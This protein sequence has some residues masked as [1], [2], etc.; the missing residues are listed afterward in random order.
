AA[1]TSPAGSIE[2]LERFEG[3]RVQVDSLT[4]IAPTGGTISEANATSTT[5]GVFYGVISGVSR[6]FREPGVEVPDPLPAGAPAGVPRFDANPER[7]RVATT[8]LVGST[9]LNVTTGVTVTN[10]VGPLDY[11]FRAYT[12]DTDPASAPSVTPNVS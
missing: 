7:L 10:L 11:G 5:S 6:P 3:M 8:A 2:Q 4:T 1:D 9:A 12:I